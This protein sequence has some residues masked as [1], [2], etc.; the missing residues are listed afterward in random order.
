MGHGHGSTPVGNVKRH[1][2]WGRGRA[3]P[4]A[5][6]N[7]TEQL[8]LEQALLVLGEERDRK[9]VPVRGELRVRGRA[10]GVS[11]DAGEEVDDGVP[12]GPDTQPFGE[13]RVPRMG[14]SDC[15]NRSVLDRVSEGLTVVRFARVAHVRAVG[16]AAV[17]DLSLQLP[18]HAV[19]HAVLGERGVGLRLGSFCGRRDGRARSP[20]GQE[21][22]GARHRAEQ[23]VRDSIHCNAW[24]F[25]C[26]HIYSTSVGT[27]T[28]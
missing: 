24:R 16:D 6:D 2:S 28:I 18:P 17:E 20:W 14:M 7:L 27:H 21:H 26:A 12:R 8:V 10:A 4:N 22:R 23:S 13:R 11:R 3:G 15:K 1:P 5:D 25:R 9:A 19:E